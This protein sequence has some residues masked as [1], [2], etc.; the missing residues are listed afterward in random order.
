MKS[1]KSA[2]TT[3]RPLNDFQIFKGRSENTMQ[4]F[5]TPV[6]VHHEAQLIVRDDQLKEFAGT[7]VIYAIYKRSE[8]RIVEILPTPDVEPF[9]LAA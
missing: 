7:P 4:P 9:L 1:P 2:R 6:M 3:R 5:G 8:N